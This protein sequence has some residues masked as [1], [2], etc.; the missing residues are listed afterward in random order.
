VWS[1]WDRLAEHLPAIVAACVLAC[2]IGSLRAA[3][4]WRLSRRKRGC[5][6]LLLA[7]ACCGPL[8]GAGAVLASGLIAETLRDDPIRVVVIGA[9]VGVT[10]DLATASGAM[11]LLRVTLR[12]VT[13]AGQSLQRAIG[14][15]QSS[16]EQQSD[17]D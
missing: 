12:L 16:S 4:R 15:E 10:V 14:P 7:V 11:A 13:A 8:A 5:S 1:H 3:N 17:S 6:D 9:A 2:L